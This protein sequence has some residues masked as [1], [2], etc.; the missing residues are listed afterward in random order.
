MT[1]IDITPFVESVRIE[2]DFE[3]TIKRA[4]EQAV[5]QGKQEFRVEIK[6]LFARAR[7]IAKDEIERIY[8]EVDNE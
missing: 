7:T 8:L 4:I 1:E 2:F 3:G 5:E 6:Q